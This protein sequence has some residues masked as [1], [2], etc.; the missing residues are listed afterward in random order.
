MLKTIKYAVIAIAVCCAPLL[1]VVGLGISDNPIGL[2]FLA[3]IGT[4]LVVL[5]TVI[6]LAVQ[7]VKRFR[8]AR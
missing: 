4:P 5:T 7:L 2:G 3:V 6:V 8:P 1:L